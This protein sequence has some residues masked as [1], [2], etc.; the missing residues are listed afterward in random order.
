MQPMIHLSRQRCRH[1]NGPLTVHEAATG[2]VC[3][4][5]ACK[6][7]KALH[8]AVLHEQER[9]EARRRRAQ[10]HLKSR[11]SQG[12]SEDSTSKVVVVPALQSGLAKL[13][14]GRRREFAR[15]LIALSRSLFRDDAAMKRPD[16]SYCPPDRQ[17]TS[18]DALAA[19]ACG[20]CKGQCCRP[21]GNHAFVRIET[22][23]Q[24][25]DSAPDMTR[26]ELIRRYLNCLPSMT[27]QNSCLFHGAEGCALPREMRSTTCNQYFCKDLTEVFRSS[28]SEKHKSVWIAAIDDYHDLPVR[29]A[30]FAED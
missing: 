25:L 10:H 11:M 5:A 21:G 1:C 17:E 26:R 7:K 19:I 12:A 14:A 24:F 4:E 8:G 2:G 18:G 22:L 6:R 29:T 13:A 3:R 20:A 15:H 27:Y 16:R 23:R 28:A 30:R 9:R